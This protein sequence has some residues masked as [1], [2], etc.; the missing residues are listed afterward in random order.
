MLSLC[1]GIGGIELGLQRVSRELQQP[2][3][4]HQIRAL[5]NSCSAIATAAAWTC[6]WDRVR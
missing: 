1:S 3:Y 6:L 5:G 4:G 2:V